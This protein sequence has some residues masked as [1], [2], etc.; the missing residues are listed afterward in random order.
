[1]IKL[2]KKRLWEFV[3]RK[4]HKSVVKELVCQGIQRCC[5]YSDRTTLT[6]PDVTPNEIPTHLPSRQSLNI[7][8]VPVVFFKGRMAE[9]KSKVKILK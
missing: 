1:M 9:W 5:L 8:F 3:E 6:V 4:D 2:E 7:S